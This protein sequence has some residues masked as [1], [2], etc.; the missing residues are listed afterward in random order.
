MQVRWECGPPYDAQR[1]TSGPVRAGFDHHH[2]Q[3]PKRI[4]GFALD[5]CGGAPKDSVE[6]A[7]AVWVQPNRRL[8]RLSRF[9]GNPHPTRLR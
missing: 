6:L 5:G 2:R 3:R 9:I 8:E 4:G 1:R 7:S